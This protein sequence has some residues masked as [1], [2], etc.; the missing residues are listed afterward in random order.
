MTRSIRRT[1]LIWLLGPLLILFSAGTLVVYQLAL[2][3]SEDAHDRALLESANDIEQL[4][5]ASLSSSGH[6]ELPHMVHDILLT[7]QYDKSY[8]SMLDDQGA[9]V[10]GDGKLALPPPD[11]D[12]TGENNTTF[13]DTTVGHEQ[14]RAI[15]TELHFDLNGESHIWRILIGETRNKRRMLA[16]D[17]LTGFVA[18][19]AFV[20][21]LAAALVLLGIRQG[22]A[23]LESLRSA[24]AKR[25]L[26]DMQPLQVREVPI[27]VQPLL[28]EINS[29]LGRLQSVLE[30][31]KR[32]TA[33]AAHQL[34]TPLAGLTA[35]T[36]LARTQNNPPQTEHALDQ[37]K[38]V[39]TRLNHVVCQLLS[40][41]RNEQGAEK[42]LRMETLNLTE[43]V[44]ETAMGWVS[45]AVE[46]GIDLGFEAPSAHLIEITGD[47]SR[48]KE[49]LDNL[50][51]NA[52]RYSPRGSQITV[53]VKPDCSL[54]VEDNGP[55]I[56]PE[57]R[58]RIFE[59]FHRLLD[60]E[61]EGSGLGLA[62]VKEIA[63]I[64][65]GTVT[66]TEGAHGRGAL[67]QVRFPGASQHQA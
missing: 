41:A 64:H 48:I 1:L 59:R 28:Q 53:S 18:P 12:S 3:Y 33:D 50:L 56:P 9:L 44:R 30:T 5:R 49:L 15:F 35:Q 19:Q 57:E 11:A 63:E 66:V 42:S 10:T 43:L 32:F 46:H 38:E 65:G 29:L 34:R 67:F 20:I 6:I 45:S 25:S 7:D 16:S 58:E 52:I 37:I 22:L 55:G 26:N 47:A 14:V 51:D 8:F 36:D 54:C 4:A 24:V 62:I 39:S 31:Q 40:L 17:I 23:P 61:S 13:Y 2:N 60:Q 21:L 27:E